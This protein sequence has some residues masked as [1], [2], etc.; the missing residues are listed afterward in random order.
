MRYQPGVS[1]VVPT[2]KSPT[3]LTELVER[4]ESLGL[5]AFEIIIVDDGNNDATWEQ[6]GLLSRSKKFVVGLR[7]GRNFGQH[8]ALLAGVR[9]AK[10]SQIVTIDDDLQNP[11][12]EIPNL[13]AKLV[14]GVDVV[15]GVSTQ[16]RQNVWRR[17]TSR[18]A[19]AIFA[20]VLGFE[21]AI[22]ISSFRAFR[23]QLREG[24]AGELGPHVSLDALL[25]WSTSRFSTLEVEH[26]ARRVGKS[27]YSFTKL[28]RFMLDTATSYSTR[29]LRLA[30]TIGFITTLFG[31]LLLVWVVGN[32]IFVGDSV[33]GFPFLAASIAVF[34]GVQLVVLGILGEYLGKIHFRAMNKPTF[35]VSETTED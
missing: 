14:N 6:I 13:L 12:E 28:V 16:V 33:P 3:T 26:H 18:T 7:L 21:S 23:T 27:N 20:K 25:T 4:T 31:L 8:S 11:P 34:S 24:F 15:Y 10:Y 29:P 5:S 22:S 35:S 19:K 1:I 9:K 2:Y 30:T 17:F 32:A